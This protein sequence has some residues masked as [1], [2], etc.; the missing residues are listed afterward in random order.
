[1][2]KVRVIFQPMIDDMGYAQGKDGPQR[3]NLHEDLR[4]AIKTPKC[5]T[6]GFIYQDHSMVSSHHG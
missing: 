6:V 3:P 1:M 2:Q 5:S 4:W